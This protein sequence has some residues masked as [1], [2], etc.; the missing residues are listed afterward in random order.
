MSIGMFVLLVLIAIFAVQFN[1]G[2]KSVRR[3]NATSA[4]AKGVR[5]RDL[6]SVELQTDKAWQRVRQRGVYWLGFIFVSL[7]LFIFGLI[8]AV[9]SQNAA[10]MQAVLALSLIPLLVLLS[11]FGTLLLATIPKSQNQIFREG[12]LLFVPAGQ[13]NSDEPVVLNFR[14]TMPKLHGKVNLTAHLVAYQPGSRE[15][16]AAGVHDVSIRL[17]V[18]GIAYKAGILR[19]KIELVVPKTSAAP[20]PTAGPPVELT[21]LDVLTAVAVDLEVAALDVWSR[22]IA[23]REYAHW[24]LEVWIETPQQGASRSAFKLHFDYRSSE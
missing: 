18:T 23:R 7:A 1:A 21:G 16:G 17:P 3:L 15:A 4:G 20:T 9:V 12:G 2:L 19:A 22:D 8:S 24:Y 13:L 5:L 10:L 14:R 11:V 6:D